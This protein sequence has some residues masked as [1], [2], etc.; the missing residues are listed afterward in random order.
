MKRRCN[1]TSKKDLETYHDRGISYDPRWEKFES[2]MT[3]MRNGWKEGLTL[4]RINNNGNYSKD[5]CRWVDRKIQAINRRTT[6]LFEFNGE[7]K[8]LTDWSPI[9]GI[10]RSTLA[11][12]FYC[13]NWSI[14][15]TLAHSSYK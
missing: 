5:N 12:R 10:K 6:R 14:E 9:V 7:S 11:M 2:F 13:L 3:D 1:G 8:T 15:R 4:D